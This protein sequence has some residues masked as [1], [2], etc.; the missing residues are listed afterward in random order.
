MSIE[1][2]IASKELADLTEVKEVTEVTKP[3]ITDEQVEVVLK[4]LKW[5]NGCSE[6]EGNE[7][8]IGLGDDRIA[9]KAGITKEDFLAVKEARE[10]KMSELNA[11]KEEPITE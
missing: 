1:T 6:T 2:V 10:A 5:Q 3:K 4:C 8:F 7:E 11:P 9:K